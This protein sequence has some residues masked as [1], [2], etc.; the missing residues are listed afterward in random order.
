MVIVRL[1]TGPAMRWPP[2]VD[3][4]IVCFIGDNTFWRLSGPA[5][6]VDA[7][8]RERALSVPVWGE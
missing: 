8:V 5:A 2:S 1:V 6:E 7:L 3:A 4:R